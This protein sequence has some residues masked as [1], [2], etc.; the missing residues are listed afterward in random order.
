M[1]SHP[2]AAPHPD[3]GRSVQAMFDAIAARYDL[4]NMVLSLGVDRSWRRRA[5]RAALAKDPA[6]ILDV[7]TGTADVALA[8]AEAR[9]NV[10]VVGVDF[11]EAMLEV[12]RSK[13]ARRGI[14]VRLEQGDGMKLGYPDGSF[15]VIT[16]AFG[17]RNFAD[18]MAG[19]KEFRRVLAPGGRLVVLEFPP[20]PKGLFG[21]V[22][23]WYFTRVVPWIGRLVSGH[24]AAY[25]YLPAST[26]AFPEPAVLAERMKEAGFDDVVWTPLTF[27]VAALHVADVAGGDR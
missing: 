20:P 4:L 17:L 11:S 5:L 19:L 14:P 9:P 13:S 7:A 22:F 10:E 6:R 8:L 1:S 2:P 16:I 25:A 3:K 21:S 26:F 12:G 23:R 27:G 15:D 24:G 18:V